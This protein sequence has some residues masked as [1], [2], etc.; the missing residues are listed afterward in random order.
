MRAPTLS[1]LLLLALLP[2]CTRPSAWEV[3]L[4]DFATRYSAAWSNQDAPSVAAFFAPAG[5]LT[6]NGGTPAVGRGAITAVV[7]GFMMAFPDMKVLMDSVIVQGSD[8]AVFHWTLIGTNNGP[9]GSG[10]AVHISGFEEWRL[11]AD[12]LIA[13][14]Q[15]HFDS[16]EYQRQ[17]TR[18][19]GE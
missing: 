6:I 7:Q 9:S 19:P 15:G 12:G 14:S 1:T 18:Q 4:R 16:A 11:G 8:R 13:E 3:T 2:G 5:S 10:R 17:L